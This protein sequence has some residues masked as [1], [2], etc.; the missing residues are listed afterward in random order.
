MDL[1]SILQGYSANNSTESEHVQQIIDFVVGNDSAY[2]RSHKGHITA[3][4]WVVDGKG[5]VLLNHHK[6]LNMWL[7][8]GGHCDGDNNIARV[9]QR[10]VLEETGLIFDSIDA[11]NIYNVAVFDVPANSKTNEPAHKHYDINYLFVTEDKTVTV[12]DESI[13]L[14]WVTIDEALQLINPQDTAVRCMLD[15][16]LLFLQNN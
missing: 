10:E 14:Q 11:S 6:K 16:Y 3:G 15:K 9:A 7:Q 2:T 12:S 13:D 1:V 4:A 8:I 5:M